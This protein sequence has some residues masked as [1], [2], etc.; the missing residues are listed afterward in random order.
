MK[1]LLSWIVVLAV[2]GVLLVKLFIYHRVTDQLD[3]A[4]ALMSPFAR[5]TYQ[6]VNSSL[7]GEV[8]VGQVMIRAYAVDFEVQ[9]EEIHLTFPDLKTLLFFR[10]DIRKQRLPESMEFGLRHIEVDVGDLKPY[11]EAAQNDTDQWLQGNNALGCKTL[12]NVD[13][14]TLLQILGYD[15]LDGSMVMAYGWDKLSKSMTVNMDFSWH[16]MSHTEVIFSFD[17]VAALSAAALAQ[18]KLKSISLQLEDLGYN[19][20]F[21][22][23]CAQQD[24]IT[25]D[26]F[27]DIH[28]ALARSV[29]KEQ[30]VSL[31]EEWFEAYDYYLKDVGPLEIS[32]YPDNMKDLANAH[33]YKPSELPRLLGLE[34]RMGD[35]VVRDISMDWDQQKLLASLTAYQQKDNPAPAVERAPE[36]L[37]ELAIR[38]HEIS[39]ERINDFIRQRVVVLTR[40]GRKF[41]GELAS[42]TDKQVFINVT[43][44][45]GYA[46]LPVKRYDIASIKVRKESVR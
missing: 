37:P 33:L 40:D 4:I 35:R 1:K 23:Y 19:K 29:L 45:S 30:G 18:P 41:E 28:L 38:Y 2:G 32:I 9:I 6:E 7:S 43:M 42:A 36:P 26:E 31:G 15:R 25:A 16:D 20:R 21:T 44:G 10:D 24:G 3:H 14:A 11:L 27:I 8:S 39:V 12:E 13:A 46:T 22:E 34:I 17:D 5:V